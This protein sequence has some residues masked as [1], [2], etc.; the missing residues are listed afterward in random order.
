MRDFFGVIPYL[1]SP[2]DRA[3]NVRGDV[4]GW[5]VSDLI[6]AGVHGVTRRAIGRLPSHRAN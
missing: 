3:G 1:V 2:I 5:L 6:A 4:L